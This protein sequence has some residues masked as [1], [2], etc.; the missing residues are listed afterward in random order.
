MRA[1]SAGAAVHDKRKSPAAWE[2]DC[3]TC[4]YLDT[5]EGEKVHDLYFHPDP[6]RPTVIARYGSRG[7]DYYSGLAFA[8][9][10]PLLAL[11]LI[12]A[13]KRG[14]IKFEDA[15]RKL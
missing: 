8:S 14:L 4:V 1:D 12:L 3:E 2:H 10:D 7:E 9:H 11:A 5:V 13:L 15:L 6:H